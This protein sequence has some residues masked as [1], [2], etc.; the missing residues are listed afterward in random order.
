MICINLVNIAC[1]L[2]FIAPEIGT[3]SLSGHIRALR[4]DDSCN[5]SLPELRR[6]VSLGRSDDSK[7]VHMQSYDAFTSMGHPSSSSRLAQAESLVKPDDV[8]NLQ[9]TS[10]IRFSG[11]ELDPWL[12]RCSGTTGSPKAAMLT[13]M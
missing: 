8:L 3:R 13:H 11:S 5:P 10:G 1:K 7:G 4:G 6:V 12:T 2:V 9:F